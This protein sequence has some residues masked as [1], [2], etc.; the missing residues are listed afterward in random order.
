MKPLLEKNP[1][2]F[3]P[4]M[5]GFCTPGSSTA[6]FNFFLEDSL[7]LVC[8][9]DNLE[10][11]FSRLNSIRSLEF[12]RNTD[13]SSL[14]LLELRMESRLLIGFL[15]FWRFVGDVCRLGLFDLGREVMC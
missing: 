14:F 4:F 1:L 6:A 13:L 10:P 2:K 15:C 3:A 11:V 12:C 5:N 7:N 9:V 8:P